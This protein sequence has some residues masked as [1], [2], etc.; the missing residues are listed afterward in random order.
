MAASLQVLIVGEALVAVV[1]SKIESGAVLKQK[2]KKKKANEIF[3]GIGRGGFQPSFGPPA[4]VL[5]K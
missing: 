3:F 5:G 1:V 4:Q 2:K